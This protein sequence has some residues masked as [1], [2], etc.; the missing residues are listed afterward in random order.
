MDW[1]ILL[2]IITLLAVAGGGAFT[3]WLNLKNA[4]INAKVESMQKKAETLLA[5][6]QRQDEKTDTVITQ[7]AK[8]EQKI[9]QMV[10]INAHLAEFVNAQIAVGR[11]LGIAE[12]QARRLEEQRRVAQATAEAAQLLVAQAK[13]AA[14]VVKGEARE[15]ANE[16]KFKV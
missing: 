1:T 13:T 9:D 14:D 3:A 6:N 5:Q 10:T 7:N 2:Q 8:Q 16:L 12:E 15:V 4:E 11:L